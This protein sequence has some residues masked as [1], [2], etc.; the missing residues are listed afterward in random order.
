MLH[1]EQVLIVWPGDGQEK[2]RFGDCFNLVLDRSAK[3]EETSSLQVVDLPLCFVT[4]CALQNLDRACA[5][6]V[7]FFYPG[8]SFHANQ[9]N[10]KVLFFEKSLGVDPLGPRFVMLE[11]SYFVCQVKLR[12]ISRHRAVICCSGNWH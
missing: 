2:T 6:C 12:K 3:S 11:L 5:V 8:G 7:V 9:N 4:E 1:G 10:S